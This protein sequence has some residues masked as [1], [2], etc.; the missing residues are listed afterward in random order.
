MTQDHTE[1]T[2]IPRRFNKVNKSLKDR[3]IAQTHTDGLS[4]KEA[5]FNLGIDYNNARKII[6]N[7][8]K[9]REI[10]PLNPSEMPKRGAPVK[11]NDSILEQV[12]TIIGE[13]TGI[14]IKEIKNLVHERAGIRLSVG[15]VANCLSKL[16]ITLKKAS[17]VHDRVNSESTLRAR[18]IYFQDFA[19]NAPGE[20]FK[21][22]FIDESGFNYHM[23]RTLARSRS[24]TRAY[25]H[26]P[27]LRGRVESLIIAASGQKIIHSKLISDG[28]CNGEKFFAFMQELLNILDLNA[29]Y[30]GAW[31]IMDNARI[32]HTQ[33][34]RNLIYSSNYLL[35]F[36][37]P[38][39][40]MLNPVEL[41]FSKIKINV[42]NR[43]NSLH[44]DNQEINISNLIGE[45]IGLI[46]NQDC[47]GYFS[48]MYRNVSLALQ[49]HKFE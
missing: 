4:I 31:I 26:T 43:M 11:I 21:C 22:I 28:T 29:T 32:H 30:S 2:Q 18:A 20:S 46:T 49:E 14:T 45:A 8:K 24:G 27:V 6:N 25:V 13:N 41:I 12:D 17:I 19:A 15:S 38:Y 48:W 39:S 37:S 16:K 47:M 34:L 9:V 40:Y 1:E 44:L 5:A 10:F 23:R 36:L 3:L 35:K 33:N 42:R 7:Y